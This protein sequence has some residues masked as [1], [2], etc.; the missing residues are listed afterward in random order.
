MDLALQ[1]H[2]RQVKEVSK[3]LELYSVCWSQR[4][5]S[6]RLCSH[7]YYWSL[8][9]HMLTANVL[10][11]NPKAT[12]HLHQ[13]GRLSVC[14]LCDMHKHK[15]ITRLK[16]RD[17]IFSRTVFVSLTH[18]LAVV[19]FLIWAFR[20]KVSPMSIFLSRFRL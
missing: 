8:I 2:A 1:P 15:R 16:S 6:C 11:A 19:P 5:A 10:L 4:N 12:S 3:V 18:S 7:A 20:S 9:A 17:C 14:H 13:S